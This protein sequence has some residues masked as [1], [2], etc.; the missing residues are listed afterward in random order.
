M[1][2]LHDVAFS[3][4]AGGA[5]WGGAEKVK[6]RERGGGGQRERERER[7]RERRR[8]KDRDKQSET[9]TETEHTS[10]M[11]KRG[12]HVSVASAFGEI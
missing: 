2:N 8:L 3:I 1:H 11:R 12:G 4:D 6:A 5:E 9:E 7:E 10:I